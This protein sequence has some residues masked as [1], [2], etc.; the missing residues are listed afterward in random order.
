METKP[1]FRYYT[2]GRIHDEDDNNYNNSEQN[3]RKILSHVDEPT[4]SHF[5][6]DTDSPLEQNTGSENT[7]DEE[8]SKDNKIESNNNINN[9][10]QK[11][12]YFLKPEL[13]MLRTR[14]EKKFVFFFLIITK[15]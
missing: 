1:S 3:N 4:L 14:T 15:N 8:D 12:N 9:N 10:H 2:T 13:S 7:C 11:V 5:N 6:Y